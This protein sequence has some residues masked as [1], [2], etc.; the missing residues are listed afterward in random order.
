MSFKT[1]V[2]I[3]LKRHNT[4]I[5]HFNIVLHSMPCTFLTFFCVVQRSEKE[6][7]LRKEEK[8]KEDLYP[9]GLKTRIYFL[10]TGKWAYKRGEAYKEGGGL[11]T[12][13]LQ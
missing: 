8:V 7:I 10:I 12:D 2:I 1:G 5:I 9:W 13:I 4:S 11:I 3:K 6:F